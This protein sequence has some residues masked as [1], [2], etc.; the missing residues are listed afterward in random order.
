LSDMLK[1]VLH[2]ISQSERRYGLILKQ[3]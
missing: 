3:S 2:H 1:G